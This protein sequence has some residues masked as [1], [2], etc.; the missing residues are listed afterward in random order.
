MSA[1]ARHRQRQQ[2]GAIS[3]IGLIWIGVAVVCLLSIDI[4]HVFW[5]KREVR[6]IADLAALSAAGSPES[7]CAATGLASAGQNGLTSGDPAAV[8][9]CGNWEPQ[10]AD[11]SLRTVSVDDGAPYNAARVT[12]TRNVPSL[13]ASISGTGS[14]PI[15]ATATAT[16]RNLAGFALGTGL[17]RIPETNPETNQGLPSL[18][19]NALLGRSSSPPLALT[20]AD[21]KA[22]LASSRVGLK[23]LAVALDVGNVSGLIGASVGVDKLLSAM[24]TV[25]GSGSTAAGQLNEVLAATIRTDPIKMGDLLGI[26][27]ANPESAAN[28]EINAFDLLMAAAM[29]SAKNTTTVTLPPVSIAGLASASANLSV[30][31]PPVIASGEAGKNAAGQWKTQAKS[32][33]VQLHLTAQTTPL[34]GNSLALNLELAAAQGEAWLVDAQC[35][36]P[37]DD[38]RVRI[39][40]QSGIASIKPTLSLSTVLS[41]TLIPLPPISISGTTNQMDFTGSSGGD[42]Q[43]TGS[44]VSLSSSLAGAALPLGLGALLTP[45]TTLLDSTIAPTLELLGVQIGYA[46]VY[47]RSLT[48]GSAQLVY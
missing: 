35:A 20:L 19:L 10:I 3:I 2:R 5:Q 9:E 14:R 7:N 6:K 23:D 36:V 13:F 21:Y 41:S 24:V 12:V 34:L 48:C 33:Q 27:T 28:A 16:A 4:G 30:I 32:A 31:Q 29:A 46:D 45:L 26:D 39:D 11:G 18:V 47:Y 40:A 43:S 25:L 37:L 22:G 15:T 38:S 8:V 44:G 1:L 17:A 42:Y